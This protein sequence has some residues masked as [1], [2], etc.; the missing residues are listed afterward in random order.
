MILEGDYN[1]LFTVRNVP[2]SALFGAMASYVLDWGIPILYART[3]DETA[4][5]LVTI[6]KREQLGKKKSVSVRGG[7]KPQT[8]P[9]MQQFFV[10]GLP[11][12]GPEAAKALLKTL[13]CPRNIA[14]ATLEDLKKV[15]N[16]GDKKAE[17]IR[18]ILDMEWV[19]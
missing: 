14:N 5:L 13:K 18:Q 1:L 9:E 15:E 2:T 4:D 11:Q 10:E 8:L 6:A 16:I 17:L 3:K 7:N 12:I 19:D